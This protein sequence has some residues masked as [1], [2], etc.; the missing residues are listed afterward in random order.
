MITIDAVDLVPGDIIIARLGDIMPADTK[1]LGE[2]DE[3]PLQASFS[4]EIF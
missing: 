2:H 1:I 4:A 3:T